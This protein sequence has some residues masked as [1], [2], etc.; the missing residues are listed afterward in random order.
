MI[1]LSSRLLAGAASLAVAAT[2]IAGTVTTASAAP[3]DPPKGITPAAYDIVGVGSNTTEYVMDQLT[4]GYDSTIKKDS[5]AK[6]KVYSWDALPE[7]ANVERTPNPYTITPK[8]GCATIERPDGSSAGITA[9]NDTQVIKYKGSSYACLNFARSSRSR[10]SSDPKDAKGGIIFVAFAKDAIT[11]AVRSAAK[12]GS[13]AP[14]SLTLAQLEGIFTCKTTNWATV[15]GKSGTIKVY[16]PQA[17]SGTL[18]TWETDMGITTLGSCVSQAPEENEGTYSGGPTHGF[19]NPNAIFI[20]SIGAYV[21][22]KY[23]SPFCGQ[24]PKK[25]QNAFGCNI[26]GYLTPMPISG[27]QPMTSAKVPTINPNFPTH[28]W[29]TVYNVVNYTAGTADHIPAQVNALFGRTGYMCTNA[30]AKAEIRDYGFVT[31]GL[32]G[33][34]S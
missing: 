16:L 14:K 18:S 22:Q 32:C 33:S 30:T 25:G 20:Y 19:N 7:G 12:G 11:W 21:A 9:L 24:A 4:L 17:G 8:A 3:N 6:P 26:T 15:G 5:P 10:K 2:L 34:E 27:V 1:K 28:F 13:N 31:T 29:R 23:H